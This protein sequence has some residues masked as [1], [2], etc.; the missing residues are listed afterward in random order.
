MSQILSTYNIIDV[1]TAFD[2][3]EILRKN[4]NSLSTN[5]NQPTSLGQNPDTVY[6]ITTLANAAYG[7]GQGPLQGINQGE[8]G[9]NLRIKANVNDV[10]RWRTVSLTDVADYKC[11][12]YRFTAISGAL[13][14]E[15]S[16]LTANVTEPYPAAGWPGSNR[17]NEEPRADYYAQATVIRPGTETYTF[18]VAIYDRHAQLKGY[19]TWDPYITANSR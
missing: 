14:S 4:N 13:L 16:Y 17:V 9:S 18:V 10:I 19:I 5:P 8:A 15:V 3:D 11:F 1:L 2:V 6:M 12:L 7:Y